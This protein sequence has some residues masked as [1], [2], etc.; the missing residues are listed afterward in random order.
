MG[1]VVEYHSF[2]KA[3]R[4]LKAFSEQTSTD[5]ELT[6]VDNDKGLGE[7]FGDIIFCRGI[8]LDHKVT[9]EELNELTS[10]VQRHLHSVNNTQNKLIREFGQVYNALEALD[11]EYIKGILCSIAATEET[12]EDLKQA[13][14]KIEEILEEQR[15][16]IGVLKKFKQRLEGYAHLSDV[17]RLWSDCR[18]WEQEIQVLSRVKAVDEQVIASVQQ[19]EAALDALTKR[20]TYLYWLF[21]GALGFALIAVGTL[22]FGVPLKGA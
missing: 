2:E 7:F 10:Q 1:A 18:R 13:N 3:K 12:S 11:K 5:L 19:T 17:D 4:E 21:G 15:R 6:K 22:F 16:T 9:G 20:I 14:G 8:G